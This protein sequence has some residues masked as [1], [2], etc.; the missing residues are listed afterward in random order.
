MVSFACH[1]LNLP[2]STHFD[3][4]LPANYFTTAYET[5]RSYRSTE[6]GEASDRNG[7]RWRHACWLI[8][9]SRIRVRRRGITGP[10]KVRPF[11][12][13]AYWPRAR[14]NYLALNFPSTPPKPLISRGQTRV[15]P[16][17]KISRFALERGRDSVVGKKIIIFLEL[18]IRRFNFLESWTLVFIII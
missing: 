12:D 1:R 17:L 4:S 2:C 3:R 9:F 6:W 13:L 15:F 8:R 14:P 5:Q 7:G 16:R 10:A 11:R 18:C